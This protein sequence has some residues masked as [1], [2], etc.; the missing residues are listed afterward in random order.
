LPLSCVEAAQEHLLGVTLA[1]L[2]GEEDPG[3]EL[4]QIAGILVRNIGERAH[5]EVEI[6]GTDAWRCR[7]T[8][9]FNDVRRASRN[10]RHRALRRRRNRRDDGGLW[11]R[12]LRGRGRLGR[13]EGRDDLGWRCG[14]CEVEWDS[15]ATGN[16]GVAP[17][18]WNERPLTDG[19]DRGLVDI[20]TSR[21]GDVDLRDVAI[22]IDRNE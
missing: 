7:T 8:V 22:D 18:R 14:R 12:V 3:S 16:G 2:V 20:G 11:N 15:D 10:R 1:A 21:R 17:H 5:V 13:H 19:D 9:N 4:E 6:R